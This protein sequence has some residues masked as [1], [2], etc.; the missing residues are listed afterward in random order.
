[1]GK[2]TIEWT[3][4]QGPDGTWR[5]GFT[6]NPWKGCTRISPACDH[7]YAADWA[8]RTGQA[9]LWEGERQRTTQSYWQQPLKW[10]QRAAAS[11]VR[12]RVFCA[13]LADV[14][15]NQVP[16]EWREDLWKMIW[17]TPHLD[18]LL[19]TKRPQNIRKML[20]RGGAK[21]PP[22]NTWFGITAENQ[23]ALEARMEHM[24][25][26][27]GSVWFIS[28]E[29]LLGPLILPRMFRTWG[30]RAWVIAGGESG[31]R[32]RPSNP[33]WFRDL[34]D[35]CVDAGVPFLFKQ[36]GEWVSV[37]EV[38]GPGPHHTFDDGRVVRRVGKKRA[39]RTLDGVV[40][41]QYPSPPAFEV[42]ARFKP[43]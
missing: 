30:K 6:F 8:K 1:M 20:P 2:T 4:T 18:W 23:T 29:P 28:A 14:F 26:A 36:W 11:G 15:D 41:D 31:P 42:P 43:E 38:E 16:E 24:V 35:Q 25:M 22:I 32:A 40:W 9:Q 13:S 17:N 27:P 33:Q 10:N 37:S 12:E 34:R 7:C 39:G 3:A 5:Q 21:L 19:L